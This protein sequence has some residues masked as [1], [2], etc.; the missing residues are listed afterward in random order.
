MTSSSRSWKGSDYAEPPH[1]RRPE[2]QPQNEV[3]RHNP[4]RGVMAK[5]VQRG[6]VIIDLVKE[7]RLRRDLHIIRARRVKRFGPANAKVGPGRDYQRL[8]NGHRLALG[9]RRR[10]NGEPFGQ[11]VAL[12]DVEQGN[13]L[14]E[15]YG[16]RVV[17]VAPRP[18][19]L[20]L[21][22][23]AVSINHGHAALALADGAASVERLGEGQPA[24]RG[25]A[26]LDDRAPQQQDINPR[27]ASPGNGVARQ[28]RRG[29]GAAPRLNPREAPGFKLGDDPRG[30]F[31]IERD[32][33]LLA[34]ARPARARPARSS[35]AARPAI[36]RTRAPRT[37]CP[38]V[39]H[40]S[41]LPS[42]HTGPRKAGWA[43]TGDLEGPHRAG[44]GGTA[45]TQWRTG[46]KRRLPPAAADLEGSAGQPAYPG[47]ALKAPR[48]TR[49]ASTAGSA[50]APFAP[51]DR[52]PQGRDTRAA[53][54]RRARSR[55]SARRRTS[56]Q[57][58]RGANP[59]SRRRSFR[60][61]RAAIVRPYRRIR[62]AD[63]E[64]GPALEAMS[65]TRYRAGSAGN[66]WISIDAPS[67]TSRRS[68]SWSW[69]W[70]CSVVQ[71]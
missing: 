35:P 31:G 11:A 16:A 30:D 63:S 1:D 12:V 52:H 19:A 13:A 56:R 2:N 7:G 39:T 61:H 5:L 4:G 62:R 59:D 14:E 15:R 58:A 10:G 25:M 33:R 50:R 20:I 57:R 22:S 8:G 49:G 23:E 6:A 51:C 66:R 46:A 24:L 3:V 36:C 68:W 70:C 40:R 47:P 17:V 67:R 38:V 71:C 27:V 29:G 32:A 69:S 48:R 60:S 43:A 53:R 18:L 44:G 42:S 34:C 65:P 26:A 9:Q 64:V 37:N 21:G 41:F 45:A 55:V 28:A 54:H